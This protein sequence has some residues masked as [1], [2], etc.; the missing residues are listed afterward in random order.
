MTETAR[1]FIGHKCVVRSLDNNVEYGILKEIEGN[2]LILDS[3]GKAHIINIEYVTSI[4]EYDKKPSVLKQ[5]F[6]TT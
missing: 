2:A 5:F 3:N 6:G 4:Q 1:K